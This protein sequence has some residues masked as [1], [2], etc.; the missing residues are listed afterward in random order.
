M[1]DIVPFNHPHVRRKLLEQAGIR[2]L[3]TEE[4]VKIEASDTLYGSEMY[5]GMAFTE[6]AAVEIALVMK[7]NGNI[8]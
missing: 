2:A 4:R 8:V 1:A 7:K 6:Q 5:P 3:S